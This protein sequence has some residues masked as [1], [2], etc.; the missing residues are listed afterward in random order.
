MFGHGSLLKINQCFIDIIDYET[1]KYIVDLVK[2]Q[3]Y[4]ACRTNYSGGRW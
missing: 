1:K 2:F 3:G 4:E